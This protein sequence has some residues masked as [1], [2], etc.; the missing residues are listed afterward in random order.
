MNKP[1]LDLAFQYW[2]RWLKPTDTVFDATCGN[3]KDTLR[4]ASLVP[5]GKVLALDIQEDAIASARK[6]APLGNVFF[7]LQSHVSFPPSDPVK[8][9]VYNLGYLPFGD[10]SIT[11][12]STTT[13]QSLREALR[14]TFWGG[15]LSLTCYPGHPEGL[16]EK[17]AIFSFL[18]TLDP[19]EWKISFHEW[20]ETSPCLIWIE[21]TN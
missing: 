11:T 3:G 4:L 19:Q 7:Y 6:T 1:H 16:I 12:L 2:K 20:K 13:L 5:Q 21:K 9:I 14:L 17:K 10:K 8:L 15:A 18:Q